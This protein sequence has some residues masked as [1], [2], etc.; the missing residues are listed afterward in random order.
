MEVQRQVALRPDGLA[1]ALTPAAIA[2]IAA[3]AAAAG[4]MGSARPPSCPWRPARLP[5]REAEDFG[6]EEA[7]ESF[8]DPGGES[9]VDGLLIASPHAPATSCWGWSGRRPW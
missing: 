1:A 8:T 5:T 9:G 7:D 6:R 2:L 3:G 4:L